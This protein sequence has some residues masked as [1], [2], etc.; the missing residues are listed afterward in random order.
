LAVQVHACLLGNWVNL[1]D[2]PGC[3]I[4]ESGS[5]PFV[6]WEEGAKIWSPHTREEQHTMYQ[7]DYVHIVYKDIDYRINPLFIQIVNN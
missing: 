4:G 2:D 1:T 3:K 7:L 6:W 5:S